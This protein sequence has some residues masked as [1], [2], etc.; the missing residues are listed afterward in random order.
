[1]VFY[2]RMLRLPYRFPGLGRRYSRRAARHADIRD[3]AV[4]L[5]GSAGDQELLALRERFEAAKAS[6][7]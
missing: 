3:T 5:G 6:G 1:V 4:R 2:P 7:S